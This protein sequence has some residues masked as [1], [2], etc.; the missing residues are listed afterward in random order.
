MDAAS[1]ICFLWDEWMKIVL[2]GCSVLC[3]FEMFNLEMRAVGGGFLV[4]HILLMVVLTP[5][6][7]EAVGRWM[8]LVC[9]PHNVLS[10]RKAGLW[11]LSQM[12]CEC[13]H[14]KPGCAFSR[15][16]A[17]EVLLGRRDAQ[18]NNIYCFIIE[19]LHVV[20]IKRFK[21]VSLHTK[22]W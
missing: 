10:P 6:L 9:C 15:E 7:A 3:M 21:A 17:A 5:L 19:L 20:L 4:V 13:R 12:S 11:W 2:K 18:T 8:C 16:P 22:V 1:F 14:R